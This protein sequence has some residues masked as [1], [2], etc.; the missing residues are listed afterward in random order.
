MFRKRGAQTPWGPR[1]AE[2]SRQRRARGRG[3]F[4]RC[5][6]RGRQPAPDCRWAWGG[7]C[8]HP[9]LPPSGLLLVSPINW[10]SGQPE[11]KGAGPSYEEKGRERTVGP[12]RKWTFRCSPQTKQ[13]TRLSCMLMTVWLPKSTGGREC[14]S[15]SNIS[16]PQ[17]SCFANINN[18]LQSSSCLECL[19]IEIIFGRYS[20]SNHLT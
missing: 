2:V 9:L 17:A 18:N 16:K 12:N 15:R 10:P 14:G 13:K 20:K 7:N 5:A 1:C 19:V 3:A 6:C 4:P 8:L 11:A